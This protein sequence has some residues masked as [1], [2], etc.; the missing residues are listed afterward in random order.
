MVHKAEAHVVLLQQLPQTFMTGQ[1]QS[2]NKCDHVSG[3]LFSATL[4]GKLR[5]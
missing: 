5:L 3:K 2:S 1:K 4:K